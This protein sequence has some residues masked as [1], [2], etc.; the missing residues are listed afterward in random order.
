MASIPAAATSVR[1]FRFSLNLRQ[2]VVVAAALAGFW[3]VVFDPRALNDGDTYWHLAAG[4][5]ILDHHQVPHLDPFSFTHAGQPWVAHEWLSEVLMTLVWRAFGWTGIVVMFGLAVALSMAL[6]T[7]RLGRW[8]GPISLA[9]AAWLSF[10]C[11]WVGLFTRPHLLALPLMIVWTET[12]LA[13]RAAK[14]P[15][16]LWLAALLVLWANLHGS[17]VFAALVAAPL[18]LEALLEGWRD[19]WAVVRPWGLFALACLAAVMLTPNGVEAIFY[20]FQIMTMKTLNGIIEWRPP[21]FT[22]WTDFQAAVLIT[23]LVCLARG[24]KV[25]FFRAALVVFLLHMAL[26]HQ[27][28]ELV[29]ALIG[30]LF[31]AEPI[32]R[33][34]GRA[35][36]KR[37]GP[38]ATPALLFA[39]AVAGLIGWRALHPVE[40]VDAVNTP[41]SALAHVPAALQARPVINT[42]SF[43][44]YLIFRGIKPFIDGRA[45]M[46]GDDFFRR[47]MALMRGDD[48]EFDRTVAQYGVA[49]TVLAPREPLVRKLDAKPGW[50]RVY[51]DRWAV[52]HVRE[53]ALATAK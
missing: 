51:A 18:A 11:M 47:D 14:Q 20:P 43:G 31:L 25:P 13:A 4:S 26:L 7:A 22:K 38:A 3:F 6:L 42:Y 24:V 1:D 36:P 19:P 37:L 41:R 48:A 23:V 49:W 34:F 29:L 2:V 27:R 17:F 52:V 21:D 28:H 40:R 39:V 45:D 50:R 53:Q 33:A 10:G 32:G 15:P 16:P 44:G 9:V 8:L 35:A 12:L 46:Y 5:W 30:P